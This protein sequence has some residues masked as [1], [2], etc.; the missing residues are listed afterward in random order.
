LYRNLGNNKKRQQN[1]N[2]GNEI[3][4][5]KNGKI[6]LELEVDKMKNNI[7]TIR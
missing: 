2:H 5:I 1:S 7:A 4:D 3:L 6:R